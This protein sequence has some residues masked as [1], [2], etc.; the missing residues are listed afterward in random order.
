M[1]IIIFAP[2]STDL[3][4]DAVEKRPLGG[5]DKT[6]LKMCEY[7]GGKHEVAVYG[8][9]QENFVSKNMQVKYFP[10]MDLFLGKHVCDLFIQFRKVWAI[11]NTV[12]YKKSIFYSQDTSETPCFNG[13]KGYDTFKNFDKIIVLSE[14]HKQNLKNAF[15]IPGKQFVIIGNAAIQHS[16]F[17][18]A[19]I[20]FHFIYCSTPYRGLH[21]LARMWKKIKEKYP[22]AVLHVFSSMAIYGASALDEAQFNDL[23][24]QLKIMDG[25]IYHGSKTE[26][27]VHKFMKRCE[28]LLYPNTYPETYCNVLMEARGCYTPFITSFKGSLNTTGNGAGI[29]IEGDPHSNDYQRDFI[30]GIKIIKDNYSNYQENCLP[31]R[32]WDYYKRDILKVVEGLQ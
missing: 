28:M 29:F 1:K 6:F 13:T 17:E 5:A 23:Y 12:E 14:F 26:K 19:K 9:F 24:E 25:V 31:T 27:E 30:E 32:T 7:L 18:C 20:P 4:P 22:P 8:A 3:T 2:T 15:D 10:F 11:P 21:V 16:K